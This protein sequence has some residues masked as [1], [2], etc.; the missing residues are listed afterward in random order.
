MT[1]QRVVLVDDIEELAELLLHLTKNGLTF[2]VAKTG[3]GGRWQ[4]EL[5]GGY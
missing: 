5:T 2:R 4:V 1:P 3:S